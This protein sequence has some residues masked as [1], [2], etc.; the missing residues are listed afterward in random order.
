MTT[1]EEVFTLTVITT[2]SEPLVA[3]I[4]VIPLPIATTALPTTDATLS[5]PLVYPTSYTLTP[6]T[7]AER[8]SVSPS[9]VKVYSCFATSSAPSAAIVS[10]ETP[11]PSVVSG[12]S[13]VLSS[14]EDCFPVQDAK[15][16]SIPATRMRVIILRFFFIFKFLSWPDK[17]CFS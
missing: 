1:F 3:V 8:T 9:F 13:D 10:P 17:V 2:V 5:S 16:R 14:P 15:E 4:V 7:V 6:P 11:A 12:A